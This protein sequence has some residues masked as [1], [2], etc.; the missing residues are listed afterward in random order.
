MVYNTYIT[1][2]EKHCVVVFS[3]L[4]DN[5]LFTNRKKCVIGHSR[6]Q[7]LGHWISSKG[8]EA[9]GKK[10]KAMVN[11]PQPKDVTKFVDVWV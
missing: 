11:W 8:V 4:K 3:I 5:Q 9:K 1:K 2:H 7:Y 6:I 10:V